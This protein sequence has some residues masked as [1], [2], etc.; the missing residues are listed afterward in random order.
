MENTAKSLGIYETIRFYPL[1][2]EDTKLQ[3]CG[4]AFSEPGTGD[5]ILSCA[6]LYGV[7]CGNGGGVVGSITDNAGLKLL[8]M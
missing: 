5:A 4:V 6:I 3:L 8:T 2:D 7:H 1:E